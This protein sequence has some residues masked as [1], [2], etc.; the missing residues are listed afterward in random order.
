MIGLG[1]DGANFHIATAVKMPIKNPNRISG[2][3][4]RINSFMSAAICS[5]P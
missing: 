3:L 5:I 4:L 1:R 2:S